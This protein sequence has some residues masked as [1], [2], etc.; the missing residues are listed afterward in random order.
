MNQALETDYVVS[1]AD[2]KE[3]LESLIARATETGEPVV[4]E[5][6]GKPPAAIISLEQVREL[7][8]LQKAQ[9]RR[10]AVD[11]IRKLQ[12]EISARFADL[13]EEES[14]Q[15]AQEVRDEVMEAV[16]AKA[17]LYETKG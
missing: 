17:G 15:F 1:E 9:K 12:A 2:A 10:E 3:R 8:A 13:T 14:E 6:E 5:R 7:Q 16:V 4:I 11:Q